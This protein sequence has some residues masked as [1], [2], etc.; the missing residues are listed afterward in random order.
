MKIKRGQV[1]WWKCPKH[2]RPHIENGTRPVVVVSNNTC[3]KASQVI[4]VVPITRS[5]KKPYPQQACVILPTGVSVALADQLTS[6]PV[7]ELDRFVCTLSDFQM[8]DVDRS[9]AV[10]LGFT[11]GK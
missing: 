2:E 5:I 10:Q 3:N 7:S 8:A 1:W 11:E 6:I 9:I 4:T